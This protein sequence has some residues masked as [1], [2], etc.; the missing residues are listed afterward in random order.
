MASDGVFNL[1]EGNAVTWG[2][3][4]ALASVRA[5][6]FLDL[7]AP[8]PELA[9][10]WRAAA[11]TLLQRVRAEFLSLKA[12]PPSA[13]PPPSIFSAHACASWACSRL[14]AAELRIIASLKPEAS[15]A[16]WRLARLAACCQDTKPLPCNC[17]CA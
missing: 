10:Q 16:L 5:T 3:E 6:V 4:E 13:L 8:S 7:P 15:H 2:R 9:A 14:A 12:S 1:Y 11:P 17:M